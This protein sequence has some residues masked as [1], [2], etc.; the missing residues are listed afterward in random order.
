MQKK[1]KI[2][3]TPATKRNPLH[4]HPLMKKGGVHKKTNKA[5]RKHSKQSMTKE[6][7][8]LI[9]S[10]KVLLAQPIFFSPSHT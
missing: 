9:I 4:D 2:A 1:V 8:D 3:I 6:W 7:A 10:K 5:M